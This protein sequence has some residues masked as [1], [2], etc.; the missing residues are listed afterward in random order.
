VAGDYQEESAQGT[1]N[2]ALENLVAFDPSEIPGGMD[3]NFRVCII[4]PW[5]G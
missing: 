3:P 1:K 2:G 5:D 4:L